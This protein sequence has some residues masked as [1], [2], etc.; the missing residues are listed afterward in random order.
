MHFKGTKKR[1]IQ[2][3]MLPPDRVKATLAAGIWVVKWDTEFLLI[4]T[5][6][7]NGDSIW[8]VILLNLKNLDSFS[9]PFWFLDVAPQSFSIICNRLGFIL[10]DLRFSTSVQIFLWW[11][12]YKFS[13]TLPWQVQAV[14]IEVQIFS[15]SVAT[16]IFLTIIILALFQVDSVWPM[17]IF[18][19]CSGA[20]SLLALLIREI[21]LRQDEL[22]G[23]AISNNYLC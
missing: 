10:I 9:L 5:N 13:L 15:L 11:I 17:H 3:I 2:G 8:R 6:P 16:H 20:A 22:V 19:E 4:L 18:G 14:G 23:C 12:A 7:L 21:C 1:S